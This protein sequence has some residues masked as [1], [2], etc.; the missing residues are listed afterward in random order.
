MDN[1]SQS[2]VRVSVVANLIT[3]ALLLFRYVYRVQR[4]RAKDPHGLL[5]TDLLR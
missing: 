1:L 4:A 5:P 3:Y 2:I